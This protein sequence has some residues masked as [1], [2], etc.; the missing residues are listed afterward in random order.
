[1]E[2]IKRLVRPSEGE[3]RSVQLVIGVV[4]LSSIKDAYVTKARGGTDAMGIKWPPLSPA[5]IA[6]RRKGPGPLR[7]IEILRDTGVLLN[8]LSPGVP[9]GA[10]YSK[11][12]D[13]GGSEQIMEVIGDTVAV[14]TNVKY[15]ATH[16][17]GDASRNIPRRQFLPDDDSQIPEE[18]KEDWTDA[19]TVALKSVLEIRLQK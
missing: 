7:S 13:P 14:G 8:S 9:N 12:T 10:S 6:R 11:P 19:A 18:W 1:M 17:Y 15:A 2:E 3:L 4:A 5:T 16:N